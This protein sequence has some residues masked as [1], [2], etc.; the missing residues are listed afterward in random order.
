[1]KHP[2]EEP[3]SSDLETGVD[4]VTPPLVP[5]G[6]IAAGAF[7]VMVCCNDVFMILF[8]ITLLNTEPHFHARISINASNIVGLLSSK[9]MTVVINLTGQKKNSF[10]F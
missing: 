9:T 3:M 5:V 7:L 1:M 4:I 2:L 6:C 10:S 8:K